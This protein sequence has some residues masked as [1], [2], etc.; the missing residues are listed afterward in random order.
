MRKYFVG[1][2]VKAGKVEE[3]LD[4]LAAAQKEI[5]SCYTELEDLGVVK[6][7]EEEAASGN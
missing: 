3:I 4:R 6:I 1:L 5:Y 2:E 7:T